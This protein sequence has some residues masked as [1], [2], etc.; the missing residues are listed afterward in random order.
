[1][2]S[3]LRTFDLRMISI[4]LIAVFLSMTLHEMAHG[5]VSYWLGIRWQNR[6]DEFL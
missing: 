1:M 3:A 6:A 2:L 4:Y 5:L